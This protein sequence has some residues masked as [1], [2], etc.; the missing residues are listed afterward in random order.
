MALFHFFFLLGNFYPIC[1]LRDQ[2]DGYL[3]DKECCQGVRRGAAGCSLLPVGLSL[4][5]GR[6][7]MRFWV[8][9][10]TWAHPPLS[11]TFGTGGERLGGDQP[12]TASPTKG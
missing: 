1:H 9:S 12:S 10:G 6:N 7:T 2:N 5:K 4:G 8:G 11:L 3:R